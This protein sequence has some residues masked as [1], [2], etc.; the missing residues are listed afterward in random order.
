MVLLFTL[1][2]ICSV[3]VVRP[4]PTSAPTAADVALAINGPAKFQRPSTM[5][6]VSKTDSCVVGG[7]VTSAEW[8]VGQKVVALGGADPKVVD[9]T[10]FSFKT[11][12][13][14]MLGVSAPGA[15]FTTPGDN[16]GLQLHCD[17]ATMTSDKSFGLITILYGGK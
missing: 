1:V 14:D 8:H 13:G 16:L 3:L 10:A 5:E 2:V 6:Y 9:Y 4:A 15:L 17:P 7:T 12:A 11:D